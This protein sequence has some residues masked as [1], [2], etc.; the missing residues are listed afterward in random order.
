MSEPEPDNSPPTIVAEISK[1]WPVVPGE[2][3]L[4]QQ[5]E[6]VIETNRMRGYRLHDWRFSQACPEP[7]SMVE[8]II[9]IFVLI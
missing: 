7:G 4:C 9:A 8:T 2:K 3:L 6:G 1:N 5:F